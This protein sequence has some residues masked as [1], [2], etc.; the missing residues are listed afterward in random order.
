MVYIYAWWL[1]IIRGLN[2]MDKKKNQSPP[3]R[4]LR[5]GSPQKS[6][7]DNYRKRKQR[8]RTGTNVS[9]MLAIVLVFVFVATYM[10]SGLGAM[11]TTPAIATTLPGFGTVTRPPIY[12][13]VIIRDETVYTAGRGGVLEFRANHLERVRAGQFVAVIQDARYAAE[14]NA[15]IHD[16]DQRILEMQARR[17]GIS[18]FSADVARMNDQLQTQVNAHLPRITGDNFSELHAMAD[19]TRRTLNLRNQMLLSENRGSV[20]DMANEREQAEYRL[21]H[22]VMSI[23]PHRGGILSHFVDGMEDILNVDNM[24]ALEPEQ[25][26]QPVASVN[27]QRLREVSSGDEI[28]KVVNS[29]TWYIALYLPLEQT[30]DWQLNQMRRIYVEQQGGSFRE[31]DTYVH[32]INHRDTTTFV[33]LRVTRFLTDFMDMRGVNVRLSNTARESMQI[34]TSATTTRGAV[35]IPVEFVN[36]I[37]SNAPSIIRASVGDAPDQTIPLNIFRRTG[38]SV[39]VLNEAVNFSIGDVILDP[40][41]RDQTYI[42]HEI[43]T[44]RGVFVL[45]FGFA[46]FVVLNLDDEVDVRGGYITLDVMDN[47]GITPASRIILDPTGLRDGQRLE[48]FN[49]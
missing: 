38:E 27:F 4:E 31:L 36:R 29:N 23:S 17:G 26:R 34:P 22:N 15:D 30:V 41:D 11:M 28:F 49:N 10:A 44:L 39:Y 43:V 12:N 24:R 1:Y 47:R 48:V 40:N 33:I 5:K 20:R 25:T 14:I 35:R 37:D 19:N 8:N 42:I 2:V 18:A 6:E 16:L 9:L 45:N 7:L 21:S 13:G 3:K 32:Y 46:D